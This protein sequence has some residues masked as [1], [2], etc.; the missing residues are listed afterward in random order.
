MHEIDARLKLYELALAQLSSKF[1]VLEA[2]LEAKGMHVYKR[3]PKGESVAVEAPKPAP[4][5]NELACVTAPGG[6]EHSSGETTFGPNWNSAVDEHEPIAARPANPDPFG[7][8]NGPAFDAEEFDRVCPPE[9]PS[10][11]ESAKSTPMST[12]CI[13]DRP[14]KPQFDHVSPPVGD[15]GLTEE[16][17]WRASDHF[18]AVTD[19]L[20]DYLKTMPTGATWGEISKALAS[21][22]SVLRDVLD[23]AVEGGIVTKSGQRRGTRYSRAAGATE[24]A[25]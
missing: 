24:A 4:E 12:A 19:D 5:D 23:Y 25:T 10:V 17:S 16:E 15:N 11:T 21:S 1:D 20:L 2:A 8:G 7:V 22:E 18:A 13:D 3:A 6:C 14:S 9:L